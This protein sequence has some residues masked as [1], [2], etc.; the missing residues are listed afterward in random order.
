MRYYRLLKECDA[1]SVVV[2]LEDLE[3]EGHELAHVVVHHLAALRNQLL[4]EHDSMR[5]DKNYQRKLCPFVSCESLRD[6]EGLSKQLALLAQWPVP[7]VLV[8]LLR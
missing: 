7:D 5:V 2:V 6:V 8:L 1:L 3:K 4:A